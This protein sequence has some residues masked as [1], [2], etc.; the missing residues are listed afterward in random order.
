MLPFTPQTKHFSILHHFLFS[1]SNIEIHLS[2][3]SFWVEIREQKVVEPIFATLA[4]NDTYIRTQK[5][6]L[7]KFDDVL[8]RSFVK[9]KIKNRVSLALVGN[10]PG[11]S[12]WR[13]KNFYNISINKF[14]ANC[15]FKTPTDFSLSVSWSAVAISQI[16]DIKCLVGHTT[17]TILKSILSVCMQNDDS[18]KMINDLRMEEKYS[19][20]FALLSSCAAKLSL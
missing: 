14:Y 13:K 6:I 19:L 10:F 2:L 18:R 15:V 9:K 20:D 3:S 7:C 8:V 12:P 4:L 11:S 17:T 1:L 16:D 5:E